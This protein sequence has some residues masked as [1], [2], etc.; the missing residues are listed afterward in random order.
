MD[1]ALFGLG[2]A[3]FGAPGDKATEAIWPQ[4][5]KFNT[6]IAKAKQLMAEAGYANGF[7][8]TLSFDLG[9]ATV[10]EPLCVL[11]QG[12]LAQLGIKAEINKVPGANWRTELNRR[13]CRFTPTCFPAGSIIPSISSSGATAARTRSS[14][15]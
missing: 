14:T 5:H 10:N 3:M 15:R 1:A 8:T 7:E 11:T 9:F 13:F 12:S 4:P 6:D 2:K